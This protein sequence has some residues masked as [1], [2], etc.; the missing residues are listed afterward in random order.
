LRT[1]PHHPAPYKLGSAI[2]LVLALVLAVASGDVLLVLA[3]G[4]AIAGIVL[5][6]TRRSPVAARRP[7]AVPVRE[8]PA[9]TVVRAPMHA[10]PRAT[11]RRMAVR[12]YRAASLTSRRASPGTQHGGARSPGSTHANV[13]ESPGQAKVIQVL[14]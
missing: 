6:T 5:L 12:R 9:A 10:R 1:A 2:F 11:S 7:A 3:V 8:R 4:T 13:A 14:Q